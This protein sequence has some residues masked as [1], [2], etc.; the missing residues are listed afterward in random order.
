MQRDASELPSP[1]ESRSAHTAHHNTRSRK[2]TEGRSSVIRNDYFSPARFGLDFQVCSMIFD[3]HGKHGA[4]HLH[5]SAVIGARGEI[6]ER[7]F[8]RPRKHTGAEDTDL[9]VVYY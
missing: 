5:P 8:R 3:D 4:A 1:G 9:W 7:D 2:L 6:L